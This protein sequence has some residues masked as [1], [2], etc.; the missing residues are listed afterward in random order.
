M[1]VKICDRCNQ[2]YIVDCHVS[3][4]VHT[5]SSGN[6][7]LDNEDVL[8]IGDWEDYTGSATVA[9]GSIPFQGQ[10]NKLWGTR[11]AIEGGDTKTLTVRGNA[12]ATHRSRQHLA[13]K[14]LEGGECLE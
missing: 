13:Y 3:D 10:A 12:A 9:D 6:A 11:G 14:N 5:C 1:V 2:A 7:T 4:Y 8:I